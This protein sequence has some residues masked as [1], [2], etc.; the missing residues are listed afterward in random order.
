MRK[1]LEI[2][3]PLRGKPIHWTSLLLAA[4]VGDQTHSWESFQTETVVKGQMNSGCLASKILAWMWKSQPSARIGQAHKHHEVVTSLNWVP[5]YLRTI[6]TRS[7]K[8][9]QASRSEPWHLLILSFVQTLWQVC[10]FSLPPS[11]NSYL[12]VQVHTPSVLLSFKMDSKCIR[13]CG[14]LHPSII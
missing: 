1:E 13:H 3:S 5:Q 7:T 10:C 9:F 4:Q 14:N 11:D 12:G 8:N 2:Q 6:N